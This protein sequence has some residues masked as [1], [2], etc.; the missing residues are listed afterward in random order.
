MG[1]MG[2]EVQMALK[3]LS[4]FGIKVNENIVAYLSSTAQFSDILS[5]VEALISDGFVSK[6]G[7]PMCYAFVHDKVREAAY[8]L[9]PD[10]E[11]DE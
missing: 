4:S 1:R 6:M 3:V 5:G 2:V 7:K 9:I 8:S 11:K 10:D